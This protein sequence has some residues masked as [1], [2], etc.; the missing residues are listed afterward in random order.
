MKKLIVILTILTLIV[1]FLVT[2]Q[3]SSDFLTTGDDFDNLTSHFN[4]IMY[5]CVFTP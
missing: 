3:N 4:P 5:P 1:L 2:A